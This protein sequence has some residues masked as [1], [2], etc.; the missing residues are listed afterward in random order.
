MD[1]ED[2]Q[3]KEDDEAEPKEK[4]ERLPKYRIENMFV[5]HDIPELEDGM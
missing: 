4:H 2:M 1:E 3:Q 5:H